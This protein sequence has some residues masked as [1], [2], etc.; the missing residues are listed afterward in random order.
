MYPHK[1]IYKLVIAII[2]DGSVCLSL[3]FLAAFSISDHNL[4]FEVL[5]H[6][7]SRHH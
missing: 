3:H 7:N 1:N 2:I 5:F 6:L 4:L